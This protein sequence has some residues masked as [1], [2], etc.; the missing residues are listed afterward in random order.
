MNKYEIGDR[1]STQ[2]SDKGILEGKYVAQSLYREEINKNVYFNTGI[3]IDIRDNDILL[4]LDMPCKHLHRKKYK[5]EYYNNLYWFTADEIYKEIYYDEREMYVN[6]LEEI[7]K[8][9][10]NL[11]HERNAILNKMNLSYIC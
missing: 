10:S 1:V 4:N 7:S 2:Y 9:M 3:I 8:E 11:R 6:R 5:G